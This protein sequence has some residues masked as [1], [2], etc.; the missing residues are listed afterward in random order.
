MRPKDSPPS[1]SIVNPEWTK[2]SRF[3]TV[4][5]AVF[6]RAHVSTYVRCTITRLLS[7]LD[8]A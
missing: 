7:S 5:T 4:E 6:I 8:P 3:R 2:Y 1:G